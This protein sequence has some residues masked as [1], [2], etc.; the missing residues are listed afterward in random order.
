VSA[1]ERYKDQRIK[2]SILVWM[3][4]ASLQFFSIM[5]VRYE[6]D[7]LLHLHESSLH[8]ATAAAIVVAVQVIR[9][10]RRRRKL[11]RRRTTRKSWSC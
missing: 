8:K 1:F 7:L 6:D 3:T 10:R 5:L 11:K 4:I 2:E 9:E